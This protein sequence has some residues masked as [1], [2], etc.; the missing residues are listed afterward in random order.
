VSVPIGKPPVDG[1]QHDAEDGEQQAAEKGQ[2][3]Q[4]WGE[5]HRE[6]GR[7]TC[8]MPQLNYY[9]IIPNYLGSWAPT[10]THL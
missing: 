3:R 6:A 5:G 8:E 10:A 7:G 1:C 4:K 2:T 9:H